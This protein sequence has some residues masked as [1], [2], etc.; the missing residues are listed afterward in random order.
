MKDSVVRCRQLVGV[1]GKARVTCIVLSGEIL[2]K[3]T[4]SV[5]CSGELS[6]RWAVRN[7]LQNDA[8]LLLHWETAGQG[9]LSGN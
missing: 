8:V 4:T 3:E 9:S 5:L 2:S 1:Y 6:A 7:V